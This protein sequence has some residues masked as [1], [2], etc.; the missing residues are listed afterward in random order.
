MTIRM[1]VPGFEYIRGVGF[2][3]DVETR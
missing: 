2:S 1:R 3:T